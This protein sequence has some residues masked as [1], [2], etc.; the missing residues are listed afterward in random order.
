LSK[1]LASLLVSCA[2]LASPTL[3]QNRSTAVEDV[4][5]QGFEDCLRIKAGEAF[6]PI[7]RARGY[8]PDD[9]GRWIKLVDE[10][11][12]WFSHDNAGIGA[13]N[14]CAALASPANA[15]QDR[16]IGAVRAK[17]RDLGLIET[18]PETSKDGSVLHS[19]VTLAEGPYLGISIGLSPPSEATP[20]GMS[21][22]MV[23][24][25]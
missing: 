5:I 3:A 12:I 13:P 8:L 23:L 16:L 24:W 14:R 22:V 20:G 18:D 10:T 21:G 25:D 6:E 2:L 11:V 19:F 4:H 15:S 9:K 17:S 1:V 7:A